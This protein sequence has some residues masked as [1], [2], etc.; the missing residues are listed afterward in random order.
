MVVKIKTYDS[1]LCGQE[2]AVTIEWVIYKEHYYKKLI[3]VLV[4]Q[5]RWLTLSYYRPSWYIFIIYVNKQTNIGRNQHHYSGY[6]EFNST[7]SYAHNWKTI[8]VLFYE[9]FYYTINTFIMSKESK[10]QMMVWPFS[11]FKNCL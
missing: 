6:Y 8:Y 10:S 9:L 11:S 3:N 5:L 4:K 2:V 7:Y 1:E